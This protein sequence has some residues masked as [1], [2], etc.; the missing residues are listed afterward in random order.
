MFIWKF[1]YEAYLYFNLQYSMIV[2]YLLKS[3]SFKNLSSGTSLVVQWLR[4]H[5]PV[6]GT[7]FQSLVQEDPTC[8]GAIKFVSHNYW[9]CVP[10]LL[11]PTCL[12]PVLCNKR[13]HRN[14]MPAYRNE[15]WPPLATTTESLRAATK[16]QRSQK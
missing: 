11:K 2:Y 1:Y 9:A 4:I 15:E 3:Y 16:T 7:W 6:Q 10:Q 14:E 5:L 8:R 13:S 12:E